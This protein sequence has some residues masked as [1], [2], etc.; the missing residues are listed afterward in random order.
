MFHTNDL[1]DNEQG[2]ANAHLVAAAPDLLNGCRA[3]LGLLQL[4]SGRD[5]VSDDLREVLRT[6]HRV[7]EAEAAIAK[8]LS[9]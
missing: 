8:A 3:L 1:D 4:I 7:E 2:E 6:N 9:P 5:D